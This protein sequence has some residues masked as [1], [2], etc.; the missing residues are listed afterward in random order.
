MK[1]IALCVNLPMENAAW[2]EHSFG[3]KYPGAGWMRWLPI[4]NGYP[5]PR[6]IDGKLA[7][8]YVK[9]FQCTPSE[10][11]VI[12]EENNADGQ[13]L[14]KL[15][16]D[17][18]VNFCLESPIYASNFYDQYYDC[19]FQEFKHRLLFVDGTEHIY[20]PSFD[21]EDLKDPIAWND[22]K[23]LCMVMSNKHYQSLGDYYKH[24]PI[25]Q[26]AMKT[27][28][29]DYRYEAVNHFLPMHELGLYGRNWG[30]VAFECDDK[31][32]TIRNYKF[33]LC[34][35]N[36]SYPGYVTEKIID[37]LVTGVIPVYRGAPDIK[38][39]IPSDFYIDAKE[40]E[41]FADMEKSLR[42]DSWN[43]AHMIKKSQEWLRSSEG[44]KYNNQVFAKR[45]L[46]LC[47]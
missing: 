27:Q 3:K 10:V 23:F 6:F 13:E 34:F 20:F 19:H 31:L 12:Q 22:R 14:I 7:V 15:G 26:M 9:E 11:V 45:M 35:E 46:E 21:D 30:G 25:Y 24:S 42:N 32:A 44:Q 37:C 29:H 1:T 39:Y 4:E 8:K 41:T 28:L 43:H 36:G 5:P 16:A 17:P 47:K 2:C 18:R 38:N 40:F 33:A